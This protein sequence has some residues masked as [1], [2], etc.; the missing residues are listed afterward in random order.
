MYIYCEVAW[1]YFPAMKFFVF[2]EQAFA[3]DVKKFRE[4]Y[5]IIRQKTV[6]SF[7]VSAFRIVFF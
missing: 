2:I 4:L 7:I 5:G 6:M 3:L 1:S